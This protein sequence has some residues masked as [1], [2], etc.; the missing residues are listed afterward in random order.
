MNYIT[1]NSI[2][3]IIGILIYLVIGIVNISMCIKNL[4]RINKLRVLVKA[5]FL[6]LLYISPIYLLPI[7]FGVELVFII[8]EYN[9]KK[10]TKLHPHV[11]LINQLIV[12]IAFV[13][14]VLFSE[15]LISIYAS[16]ILVVLAVIIDLIIHV[17]EF[18]HQDQIVKV[19]EIQQ[20]TTEL[21]KK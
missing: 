14:L 10:A 18:R 8:F 1:K 2:F 21:E 13:I 20:L 7:A 4:H 11:W 16:F 15:S 6:S 19:K 12:N 9:I 17:N 3:Y 5:T